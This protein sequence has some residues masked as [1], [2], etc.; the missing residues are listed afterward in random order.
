MRDPG[1][2]GQRVGRDAPV[3]RSRLP[4]PTESPN[5]DSYGGVRICSG[6]VPSF[7]GATLDVDLTQ[8]MHD[9]GSS[10]PLIV[11]LHG[12]GNNKHEWE[13]TNDEGDGADKYHWNNHWFAK[14]GYYVLNY[15]ARGFSDDGPTTR[16]TSRPRRPTRTAPRTRPPR[17]HPAQEPR[18][19]D[20]RHAVARGARREGLPGR[21][22][23]AA[24]AV[25]GGS[26]GG[27][28]SWLQ[29][30]Q[31]TWTFPH[32]QDPTLPVLNLQVAVPK[33]PSTDLAYSLA[34]NGHGGGPALNDLYESSQGT[35]DSDAGEGNPIG[36]PKESYITGLFALGDDE[37]HLR[38]GHL[39]RPAVPVHLRRLRGAASHH[40]RGTRAPQ[41]GD[42]DPGQR[43]D[44]P[45]DPARPHRVPRRLLPG[46]GLGAAGRLPQGRRLLDPGLDRRPVPGGRVVPHVQVPEAAR[47]ALAGRGRAGGRRPLARA[48][49]AR[50]LAA[51][52]RP[53]VPVAPV[54]H[55]RQPRAA[56][57]RVERGDRLRRRRRAAAR[58]GSHARGRWRAASSTLQYPPGG[59][60]GD[61]AAADPN[62]PATDAIAGE[63]VAAGRAVPPVERPRGRR[64]HAVLAP[65]QRAPRPTSG[66]AYVRVPY[67]W[68]GGGSGML[69]ARALR[70]RA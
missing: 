46:R 42:P 57:D 43:P 50:H 31:A 25:T 35:P 62:G 32:Q 10:H 69:A 6:T 28:E 63:I 13:S 9:T 55:R 51:A 33:Y 27:I 39:R 36:A 15:T 48:E 16:R 20:P 53:G 17:L 19:R 30:S 11:M 52:Q 45:A 24:I 59:T 29:A 7:D 22:L 65:A 67:V 68:T 21:R 5:G 38:G 44:H 37:G 34:P 23:R 60:Q 54:E 70:R 2:G 41:A 3:R 40:R 64:L 1:A 14:H 8:P 4:V 56:D 58:G 66:S 49:Q 12:F 47:P 18:L 61:A 26:Y